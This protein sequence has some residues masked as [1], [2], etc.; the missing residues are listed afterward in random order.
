MAILMQLIEKHRAQSLKC[1][2]IIDFNVLGLETWDE[3]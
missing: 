1:K 3:G 2:Q